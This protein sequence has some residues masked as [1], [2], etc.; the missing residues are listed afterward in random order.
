MITCFL[1][2]R[3]YTFNR[4]RGIPQ[5]AGSETTGR[6]TIMSDIT[7]TPY[8]LVEDALARARIGVTPAI[9]GALGAALGFYASMASWSWRA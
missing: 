8:D 1:M 9:I 6:R 4:T 2:F 7:I 3:H 5:V